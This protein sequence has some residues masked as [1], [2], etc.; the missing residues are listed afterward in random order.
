ML[1]ILLLNKA[2]SHEERAAE[3]MIEF[4]FQTSTFL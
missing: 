2:D 1:H 3:A 4:I